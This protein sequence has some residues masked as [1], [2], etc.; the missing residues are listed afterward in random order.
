MT[1]HICSRCGLESHCSHGNWSDRHP[2]AAVALAAFTVMFSIVVVVGYPWLLVVA[3]VGAVV[4]FV[5]RE[6]RRRRAL[7]ARAD[8]EHQQL[9]AASLRGV[10]SARHRTRREPRRRPLGASH[11]AVTVPMRSTR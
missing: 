5:D 10:E 1:T 9:I 2:A 3:A 8:W 11:F 4:Y 6:V 7:A